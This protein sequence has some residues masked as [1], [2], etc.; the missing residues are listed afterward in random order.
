MSR[1]A[2]VI[3]LPVLRIGF[4]IP[5]IDFPMPEK[6]HAGSLAAAHLGGYRVSDG[7]LFEFL[8]RRGGP[9]LAFETWVFCILGSL[10]SGMVAG[11]KRHQQIK[12]QG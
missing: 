2:G 7:L 1:G 6:T 3:Q 12:W 8:G 10:D 5:S 9:G 4:A 11:L